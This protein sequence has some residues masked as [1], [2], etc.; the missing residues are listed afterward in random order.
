MAD[1]DTVRTLIS[2]PWQPDRAQTKGDGASTVFQLPNYPLRSLATTTAKV[3]GAAV[4]VVS[5]ELENGRVTLASVPALDADV[6]VD[7]E[8]ALLSD[9]TVLDLLTLEGSVK[10]AAAQALDVVATSEV[11]IQK[12]IQM[13][14]LSTDGPAV[15]DALHRR[16][17][18]L[19]EQA[20]SGTGV[21]A[22][23]L[24]GAFAVAEVA[25]STFAERDLRVRGLI[26][27][28]A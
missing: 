6:L 14:D 4:G 28:D 22:D 9:Q 13:L 11:L 24:A 23:E 15:A 3:N 5:A 7:Y 19:R 8:W 17:A 1:L 16:A 26:E 20:M 12:R 18:M 10:M 21:S 25:N 27:Q 2:D